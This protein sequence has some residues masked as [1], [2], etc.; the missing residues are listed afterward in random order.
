[1]WVTRPST[2]IWVSSLSHS[3]DRCRYWSEGPVVLR[4]LFLEVTLG[5]TI[6]T[7]LRQPPLSVTLP[8]DGLVVI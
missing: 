2:P 6:T 5:V 8:W 7:K 1:M 3:V 4:P